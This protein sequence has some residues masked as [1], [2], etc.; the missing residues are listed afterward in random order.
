MYIFFSFAFCCVS[1]FF[2]PNYKF[3]VDVEF[4]YRKQ[5]R[6]LML[7]PNR[8]T[9]EQA[10]QITREKQQ[11][12]IASN[13]IGVFDNFHNN[14]LRV[15]SRWINFYRQNNTNKKKWF[16]YFFFL[17]GIWRRDFRIMIFIYFLLFLLNGRI[18]YF[19]QN[20]ISRE[21]HRY[22]HLFKLIWTNCISDASFFFFSLT[23]QFFLLFFFCFS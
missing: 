17:F 2:G 14:H 19:W 5:W 4:Y 11:H 16:L 6:T 9:S 8:R 21:I 3:K 1:F 22:L 23:F 12:K 15:I 10:I 7:I 18:E 13:L 20:K